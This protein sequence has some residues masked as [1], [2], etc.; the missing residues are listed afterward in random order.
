MPEY[1]NLPVTEQRWRELHDL[2]RAGETWDELLARLADNRRERI[3][4]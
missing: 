1:K 3:D 2:K 4:A